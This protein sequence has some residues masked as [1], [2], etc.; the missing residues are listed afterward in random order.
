MCGGEVVTVIV[1]MVV[2][3]ENVWQCGDNS[4]DCVVENVWL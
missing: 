1:V 2:I 3:V 4:R